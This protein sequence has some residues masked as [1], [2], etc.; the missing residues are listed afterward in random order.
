MRGG[1]GGGGSAPFWGPISTNILS[2]LTFSRGKNNFD[3]SCSLWCQKLKKNRL[4]IVTL[5]GGGVQNQ[6]CD[7]CHTFFFSTLMAPLKAFSCL[8]LFTVITP[9]ISLKMANGANGKPGAPAVEPAGE[10]RDWDSGCVTHQHQLTKG[11]AA[12][13]RRWRGIRNVTL[14]PAL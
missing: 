11:R 12:P 1:R 7:K 9:Q 4:W 14:S 6:K 8:C 10:E 13:V 2:I 5:V 3:Q